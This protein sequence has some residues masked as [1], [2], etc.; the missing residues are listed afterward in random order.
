MEN[1]LYNRGDIEEKLK[2]TSLEI[3]ELFEKDEFDDEKY[4]KLLYQQLIQGM[5]LQ[6]VNMNY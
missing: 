4:T 3:E 1:Q 6:N 5:Y 2:K